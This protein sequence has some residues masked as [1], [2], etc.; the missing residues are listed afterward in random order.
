V[1]LL[2]PKQHVHTLTVWQLHHYHTV[3]T[4]FSSYLKIC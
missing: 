4:I 1:D 3:S 2:V